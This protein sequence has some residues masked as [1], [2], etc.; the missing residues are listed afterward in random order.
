LFAFLVTAGLVLGSV[1]TAKA[2]PGETGAPPQ[3]NP[4]APVPSAGAVQ[5]AVRPPVLKVD[6]GAA[7]PQQALDEGQTEPFSVLTIVTVDPTGHVTDAK[8]D[9]PVG[10][11]FDEAAIAAA[12][13]LVFDPA[14]RTSDGKPVAARI[15]FSYR[16]VPPPGVLAGRVLKRAVERPI[17]GASV[18][19]RD[20]SGRE[21]TAMSAADG[22]WRI[23]GVRAGTL[24]IVVRAPNLVAREADET[25]KPGQEIDVVDRL[26]AEVVLP[27]NIDAGAADDEIQEVEVH[28][29]KPPREVTKFTL[30]EREISRIPGTGGD[31]LR[32]LQSLPGV[33]RPPPLSGLLIVRGSAPAD[34][35][36]FVDGTPVPIVYHFGG[37]SSVV[38]TEMLDRIDFYPGN[39]SS[40][41]GRAMGG[42]VDIGLKDPK[43]DKVHGFAELDL[44]DARGLVQGPIGKTGWTFAVAGRRSW[45]DVWLAPVLKATGAGVSVAP[46]YYDYQAILQRDLDKHS[47]VRFAV[48]G[49]DDLFRILLNSA[50]VS[51]P[52]LSGSIGT[53]TGF[54]RAQG[55]YRNRLTDDTELRFNVAAGE[56]SSE[57]NIGSIVYNEVDY[58]ITSRLEVSHKLDKHTTMN[59]G[60]DI[61][62][63]P[64]AV[65]AQAPPL[66]RP[67]QPPTGPFGSQQ[68]LYTHATSDFFE[69]AFYTEWELTPWAGGRL[70]PG[71]R[72]DYDKDTKSWDLA[73][74]FV[75]RQDITRDPRTTVKA[76][77][78]LF[79]EP[80]TAQQ[81]N[82]V[83]GTPGLT[84]NR[85]YHYD[86]GIEREFTRN[87]EGSIEGFYKQLDHLVTAG[88]GNTGSGVIYGSEVLLRYKP[89][90]RFFGWLAYT[91]SRSA[92]RD[93]PGMPL[94]LSQYDETHV[95]TVLGSYRLG[96]GWE[97]GARYRLT[98]GYMY[99]PDS[100]GY[101]DE[102]AATYLPIQGYPAYGARNPLFH[103]LD[104]RVDKTW[105]VSW[106]TLSA[107]LDVL[108]VYNQ[109]N[110]DGINYD[111]NYTHTAPTGDLPI[112]PSIGIRAEM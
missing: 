102:T 100:Y 47:N 42:I 25:L 93:A 17:E 97:F 12:R 66:P 80:P 65:T 19:V 13:S 69:P 90:E 74:R 18:V 109:T 111:Y 27:S 89:D 22:A 85:A 4:S 108:N 2:A 20:A 56:D 106:G 75:V 37:L 7:Y 73:P 58:P 98:S 52:Q 40:Q 82:S 60:Y 110:V 83:F 5:P 61:I 63:A 94:H 70:V 67:G 112:L 86:L 10:H 39:F 35:G 48:F 99:T 38:P 1:R 104:L 3:G 78:G 50:S 101:F 96:G 81:T 9:K 6:N 87:I 77:A 57:F 105:K 45:F 79:A 21:Y 103:S 36:Y 107:Y 49:S 8:V 14:V 64:Y 41:Y 30:E 33:A 53:H 44:I 71:V 15:R 59:A 76:G 28:G 88:L 54:W 92:R 32:S 68:L 43:K 91:L 84:S 72:L 95:L 34:T 24:H 16:F 23:S 31:A 11:G 51:N 55:L 26:E 46:V 62:Y 29:E